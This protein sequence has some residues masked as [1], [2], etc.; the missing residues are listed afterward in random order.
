MSHESKCGTH[1]SMSSC[2]GDFR[3]HPQCFYFCCAFDAYTLFTLTPSKGAGCL[4][5]VLSL[6][7][8]GVFS[9][10]RV[11]NVFQSDWVGIF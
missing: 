9:V 5:T 8:L 11:I 10:E 7:L 3:A 6:K 1:L 2:C 4:L